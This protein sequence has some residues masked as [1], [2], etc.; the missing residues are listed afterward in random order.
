MLLKKKV[1]P[2]VP[3]IKIIINVLMKIDPKA[4]TFKNLEE[5]LKTC[6]EFFKNQFKWNF[7]F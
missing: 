6:K 7:N 1:G 3:Q 5:I 4:S 2:P